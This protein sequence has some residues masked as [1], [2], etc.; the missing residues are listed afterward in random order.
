MLPARWHFKHEEKWKAPE[1]LTPG[2]LGCGLL[3]SDPSWHCTHATMGGAAML[4]SV[5]AWV[6]LMWHCVHSVDLP[7]RESVLCNL[8]LKSWIF[9]G[10]RPAF[11]DAEWQPS[12][13]VIV[14]AI[15]GAAWHSQQLGWLGCATRSPPL[16]NA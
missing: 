5:V 4:L 11:F 3:G 15:S 2:M 8:W 7:L 9:D 10:G 14:G 13:L 1:P 6:V 16:M 12:Q